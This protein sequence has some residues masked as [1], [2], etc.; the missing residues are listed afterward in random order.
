M[1][2]NKWRVAALGEQEKGKRMRERLVYVGMVLVIFFGYFLSL[3]VNNDGKS[4]ITSTVSADGISPLAPVTVTT[5]ADSGAGSL[6]EAV[7]TANQTANTTITFNIPNTDPGFDGKVFLIRLTTPLPAITK[8]MTVIDGSTQTASTGDTNP[9]GP[10]IVIDGSQATIN[11][12]GLTI[13]SQ[14]CAINAVNIRNFFSASGILIDGGQNT[15]IT[16]S[17]IGTDET[18]SST[19]GN[20]T[21]I[22]LQNS[23]NNNTVG[24][25][26]STGNVVSG[27]LQDGVVITGTGSDSN[28]VKGNFIGLDAST[29]HNPLPNVRNGLTIANGAKTNMV[30]GT[31]ASE[32]NAISSNL[33]NG[34]I[35]S[36][37]TTTGNIVQGNFIGT[38]SNGSAR[39]N[40]GDG[41]IIDT[42][43]SNT[44][45]AGNVIAFNAGNG[46]TVG[47]SPSTATVNKNKITQNSIFLNGA[48]GIDLGR[49]GVTANDDNDADSGVNNLQNYPLITSVTPSGG[50]LIVTG[51]IDSPSPATISIELFTN[52][53][54]S[55][56]SDASGFGEGQ[57]FVMTVTPNASGVFNATFASSSN[58]SVSATATD[59]MGNT[60]EFSA[61]FQIGTG[62]PD[63]M[64]MNLTATPSSLNAGD[65]TT[66]KFTLRNIGMASAGAARQD[67][68]L[69]ADNVIN[70]QDQVLGSVNS[71]AIAPQ[72]SQMLQT[73]VT[74]PATLP[75]GT[76]FLAVVADA[77]NAVTESNENNNIT[78]IQI[79]VASMPDLVINN[80]R[81]MPTSANPGDS[82][83]V[84]FNVVNQGTSNAAAHV[85]EIV[86]SDDNTVSANDVVLRTVSNGTIG[87]NGSAQ[88][89]L[90]V[91]IPAN[92][93]PGG[94]FI[95]ATT[96]ARNVVTETSEANN[97]ASATITVSG[98]VD[99]DITNL[100]LTPSNAA[101]N[102]PINVSFSLSN[103][104]TLAA[105]ASMVDIRYST[106]NIIDSTDLLLGRF[107]APAIAA[108][109]T[110]ALSFMVTIPA[111]T[112]AGQAFIGVIAD[113]DNAI[114]EGN[115]ANNTARTA[116]NTGDTIAP[117]VTVLSP[118]GGETVTTGTTFNITWTVSD[119]VA[120]VTQDIFLSTDGGANFNQV[121]ATG[122][123]GTVNSFQWNVPTNISSGSARIQ[124]VARDA[125]GNLG[126]DTSDSSFILGVRPVLLS[127]VYDAGKLK[128]LVSGSNIM[129]GASLIVMNGSSKEVF[130]ITTNAA[131]T[132][133]VVKKA[134]TS[135]PSGLK[136]N[137]AIPPGVTVQLIVQNPDGIQSAPVSFVR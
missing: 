17:Y 87:V 32:A 14:N 88:F 123:A 91:Q 100:T 79:T 93:L 36:G 98:A 72:G 111:G 115:E 44:I 119:N 66:V 84:S 107:S 24:G 126:M 47:T 58:V 59:A 7:N 62:Q 95:I 120:V 108:G 124:I 73:D 3:N 83:N 110:A 38:L 5:T 105:P 6:R 69:S 74:I 96:D 116:F 132:R 80:F 33:S 128:F 64:S 60:S 135:S 85:E 125:S 122:L 75:A 102:T 30:G 55:P 50:N 101:P 114:T 71:A 68:V 133:Y 8:D 121:I 13:Q 43:N 10:E 40:A 130:P 97:S 1:S 65:K 12:S 61:T 9:S 112:P 53:L 99:F 48:L 57:T 70:A 94:Y 49:D 45:G 81:V 90:D 39:G 27:N 28:I 92:T 106:D 104:G 127:P 34:I 37:G 109:D 67:I 137:R 20:L 129:P 25:T 51:S 56:G 134:A 41:V 31:T 113:A 11:S 89:S 77:G 136:L 118:N 117:Q 42:A 18:G 23:A 4:L 26:V 78:M 22:R 21:G 82:V 54:P 86:L 19:A 2:S 131:G 29:N 16:N 35:I 46:V 103:R 52:Q 15:T 63:L 76:Y